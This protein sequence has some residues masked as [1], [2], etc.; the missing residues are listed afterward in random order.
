[1]R[2]SKSAA[3]VPKVD[4][5]GYLF[6]KSR[7]DQQVYF[8]RS[9]PA[10]RAQS[11]NN[12]LQRGYTNRLE[13]PPDSQTKQTFSTTLMPFMDNTYNSCQGT[14]GGVGERARDKEPYEPRLARRV[15]RRVGVAA[16]WLGGSFMAN[17][18]LSETGWSAKLA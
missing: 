4:H 5:E 15:L 11:R 7:F 18:L 6:K 14:K 8:T 10:H 16:I 17:S 13:T 9:R 2:Q 3:C 1:M 12:K